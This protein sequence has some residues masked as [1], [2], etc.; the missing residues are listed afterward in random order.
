MLRKNDVWG[1]RQEGQRRDREDEERR[2]KE[3]D[4][5]ERNRGMMEAFGPMFEKYVNRHD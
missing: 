5:K 2:Q 3:E 4:R 1:A